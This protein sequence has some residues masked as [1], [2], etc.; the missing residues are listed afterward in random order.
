MRLSAIGLVIAVIFSAAFPAGENPGAVFLMIWP[1]SR[2]TALGGAFTAIADD[3]TAT[4]YN[5]GGLGFQNSGEI[6]LQHAN[7]LPGLYPG[8]YYEFLGATRS[9]REKGTFGLNIIYLTTGL[10]EVINENG[11]KLGE[12]TTFDL[13][14]TAAYGLKVLP[15]LSAG[16]SFK[17]IYSF[18]VPDW[19]FLV[20]QK[21]L[22][23]ISGG[24]GTTW[25]VDV[26]LLYKPL[27]FLS[28]GAALQ[29][30]GPNIAYT[31]SGSSDPLPRMLRIGLNYMPIQSKLFRLSLIPEMTKVLVGMFYDPYD[32][33]TFSQELSYEY[34]E[35]W[36]SFGIELTYYDLLSA[37]LGYF[38][39]LTGA[40]G[41]V[42]VIKDDVE[43]YVSL[44][45]FIFTKNRGKFD[46]IGLTFGGGIK[47]K[48]FAFD[49]SFDHLIY[50]FSTQNWKVSFSYKF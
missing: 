14:A 11:E 22:G 39:D 35:A 1:G 46:K 23:N 7:W 48:K 50:D 49:I 10:T 20:M 9:L 15:K 4:Y 38:E 16:V 36:K 30:L 24:V 29:N 13:A 8:M 42:R 31:T 40:R 44:P 18:L 32:T 21:E 26:G 17:F 34:K 37:R 33:L 45:E 47:F 12:Y 6:T 2:P 5:V 41:G 28:V 19:V 27:N 25:A 3:A 43:Q